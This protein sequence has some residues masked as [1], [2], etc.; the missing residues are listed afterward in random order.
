MISDS[1]SSINRDF[2]PTKNTCE[3]LRDTVKGISAIHHN[4]QD[5]GRFR[6]SSPRNSFGPLSDERRS[7]VE[8][9]GRPG[10]GALD[11]PPPLPSLD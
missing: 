8:K 10:K 5:E 6:T 4:L 1:E 9:K 11:S 3:K 7:H 2:S